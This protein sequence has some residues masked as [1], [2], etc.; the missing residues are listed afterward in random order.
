MATKKTAVQ[1]GT[2][3]SNSIFNC[4]AAAT[5]EHDVA[6]VV[7]MSEAVREMAIAMQKIADTAKSAPAT[8]APMIS[9]EQK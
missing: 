9:I 6:S 5:S 4:N 1:P 3:I 7:A 2:T 8:T